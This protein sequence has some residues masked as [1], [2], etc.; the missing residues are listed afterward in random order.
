MIPDNTSQTAGIRSGSRTAP[1][2]QMLT[3]RVSGDA[4]RLAA[5]YVFRVDRRVEGLCPVCLRCAWHARHAQ[6]QYPTLRGMLTRWDQILGRHF[7][8]LPDTALI[9]WTSAKRATRPELRCYGARVVR[10]YSGEFMARRM[11]LRFAAALLGT[12]FLYTA[13]VLAPA[14]SALG[15]R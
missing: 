2:C 12:S 1:L 6:R 14:G 11:V 15:A 3:I 13:A 10:R 4:C 9:G 5:S 7:A 8:T